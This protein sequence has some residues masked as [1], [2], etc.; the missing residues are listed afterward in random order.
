MSPDD[1]IKLADMVANTDDDDGQESTRIYDDC[2]LGKPAPDEWF[3]LYNFNGKGLN[4][5]IRCLIAKRKDAAGMSQPYLILGKDDFQSKVRQKI[6]PTQYVRIAYGITSGK[7]PFIWPVVIVNDIGEANN[8]WHL[9]AWE[10]AN[11]AL[12]RWSQISSD[13]AHHRYV[14][15]DLDKQDEVP[16]LDIY[17]NPPKELNYQTAINKAFKGRIVQDETHRSYSEAGSVIKS[18][19]DSPFFKKKVVKNEK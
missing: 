5:F 18:K 11:A 13:K 9:T 3:K 8:K 2:D 7:R 12:T 1:E 6:R 15:G 17:A 10:I 4:G 16:K 19:V 14:H